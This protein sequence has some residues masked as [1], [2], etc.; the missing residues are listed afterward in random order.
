LSAE[1][2]ST[3][4]PRARFE[5]RAWLDSRPLLF[6]AQTSL[7][8]RR[9][10][11]VSRDTDIVIEG[12]PRSG[13][14]YAVAAFALAQPAPIRIARHLHATAQLLLAARYGV[15]A[16]LVV[17]RVPDPVLSVVVREPYL[18]VARALRWYVDFHEALLAH[19]SAFECAAFDQ[20]TTHYG[21]VI[22]RVNRRYGTSFRRYEGG[23]AAEALVRA[24]IEDMERQDSGEVD[25]RETFVARPSPLRDRL[26]EELR[27]QYEAAALA[28][29]RR[30]AED[31]YREFVVTTTDAVQGHT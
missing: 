22:D 8:G 21:D 20:V 30:A 13:N 23:E 17:R 14:T 25:V 3:F 7:R 18:T 9:D 12:F 1:A 29:L 28:G 11:A 5:A 19:R 6:R 26:K 10:L 4:W 27:P 24:R 16:L 31:L 15:A 2:S